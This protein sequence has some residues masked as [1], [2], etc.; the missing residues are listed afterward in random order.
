M[1]RRARLIRGKQRLERPHQRWTNRFQLRPMDEGEAVHGRFTLRGERQE[2][3]S[4]VR[5]IRCAH[6][7]SAVD[8]AIQQLHGAVVADLQ[9]FRQR[10]HR[11][12]LPRWHASQGEKCLVLLGFEAC[13]AGGVFAEP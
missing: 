11:W 9:A 13:L 1:G 12:S 10:A 2:D 4:V 6:N 8:Q 3:Q 5:R 7:E